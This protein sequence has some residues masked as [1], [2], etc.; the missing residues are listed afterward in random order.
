MNPVRI[1]NGTATVCE[2]ASHTTKV[3]H[4]DFSEKAVCLL[5]MRKSGDLLKCHGLDALVYRETGYL[6]LYVAKNGCGSLLTAAFLFQ[7]F[8]KLQSNY[9]DCT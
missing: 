9:Q 8:A 1:R 3:G 6:F 2:E 7:V 4:W 5:M